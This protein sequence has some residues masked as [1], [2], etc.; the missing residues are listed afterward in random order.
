MDFSVAVLAY[1]R[2][3][4]IRQVLYALERD[5]CSAVRVYLDGPKSPLDVAKQRDLKE[6]LIEKREMAVEVEEFPRSY[7]LR[8]SVLRCLDRELARNPAVLLLEDDCVPRVGLLG[9]VT[10]SLNRYQSDASIMSVC[11]FQVPAIHS[12]DH[13]H[14]AFLSRRFIPW[15][16]ATWADRWSL[17]PRNA[18]ALKE[19]VRLALENPLLP[20]EIRHFI[21]GG[22]SEIE[23]DTWSLAW[24]LGHYAR[25][26]F[27]VMPTKT[28]IDNI[29]FDGSGSHTPKSDAFTFATDRPTQGNSFSILG[30]R[31]PEGDASAD[32]R[33]SRILDEFMEKRWR[34]TMT[35]KSGPSR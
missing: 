1:N 11:A 28:L 18:T 13:P 25:Q 21:L 35:L 12:E 23:T 20:P 3:H 32:P 31:T 17:Y 8:G 30:T 6:S 10:D 5:G 15:G 7:G 27:S 4:H 14:A 19:T 34:Q 9:Y 22:I 26:R 29:G 33:L 16:W 2:P 24:I